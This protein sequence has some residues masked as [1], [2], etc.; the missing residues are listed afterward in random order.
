M[1]MI[2][3]MLRKFRN[4]I[5]CFKERQIFLESLGEISARL[6]NILSATGYFD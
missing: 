2:S 1:A 3:S 5:I 6:A 4:F